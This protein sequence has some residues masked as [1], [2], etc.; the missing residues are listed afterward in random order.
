M[1]GFEQYLSLFG[2][3]QGQN[4]ND[5]GDFAVVNPLGCTDC[6]T[7]ESEFSADVFRHRIA[8]RRLSQQFCEIT[9][10]LIA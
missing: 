10:L 2:H 1:V 3:R 9:G 8:C 7:D 6:F 4:L 5:A